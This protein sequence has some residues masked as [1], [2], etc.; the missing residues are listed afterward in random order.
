[1]PHLQGVGAWR[2]PIDP[3]M[4]FPVGD[5]DQGVIGHQD[6]GPH[7]GVAHITDDPHKSWLGKNR[8]GPISKMGEGDME[9]GPPIGETGV[10][11]ME[12]RVAI[13]DN[14]P[15]AHGRDLDARQ[16]L[17]APVVQQGDRVRGRMPPRGRAREDDDRPQH[18]T[19]RRELE[20][21]HELPVP[22]ERPMLADLLPKGLRPQSDKDHPAREGAGRADLRCH[23]P[24]PEE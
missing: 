19:V 2:N 13:T 8:L 10:G 9:E 3:E 22:T 15:A 4:S 20:P 17:A 5:H 11:G 23:R 6:I 12:D 21:I 18:P 1:M 7:P 24:L 16:K 14:E